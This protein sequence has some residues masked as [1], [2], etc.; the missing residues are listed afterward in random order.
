MDAL[1]I[2]FLI[3]GNL[4]ALYAHISAT[5]ARYYTSG[6]EFLFSLGGLLWGVGSLLTVFMLGAAESFLGMSLGILVILN[7]ILFL[8]VVTSGN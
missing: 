8:V 4:A 3:T 7:V 6:R 5:E 2:S 1:I